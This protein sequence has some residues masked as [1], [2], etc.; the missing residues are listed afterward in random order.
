MSIFFFQIANENIHI[1][2]FLQIFTNSYEML[3]KQLTNKQ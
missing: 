2:N 1:R 3:K